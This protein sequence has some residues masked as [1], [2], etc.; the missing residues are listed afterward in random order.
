VKDVVAGFDFTCWVAGAAGSSLADGAFCSGA[1]GD[2]QLGDG[3]LTSSDVPVAVD[4]S[5]VERE[6]FIN[7]EIDNA[8]VKLTVVPNG[9]VAATGVELTVITNNLTG[10]ELAVRADGATDLTCGSYAMPTQSADGAALEVNHWGYQ[11]GST[12]PTTWNGITI[13][14]TTIDS[15]EE[16]TSLSGNNTKTWFGARANYSLPACNGYVGMVTFTAVATI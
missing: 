2:G 9:G 16:A 3:L 4:L 14:D 8:D 11:T 10:Y 5:E 15:S 12:E 6:I 13:T 1:G 7:L